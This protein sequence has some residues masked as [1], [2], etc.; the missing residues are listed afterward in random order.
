MRAG[1][2]SFWGGKLGVLPRFCG[3]RDFCRRFHGR[4]QIHPRI[5][6]KSPAE[7]HVPAWV[8]LSR[9]FWSLAPCQRTHAVPDSVEV[10]PTCVGQFRARLTWV[11]A[12][13]CLY[14]DH[15]CWVSPDCTRPSRTAEVASESSASVIWPDDDIGDDDILVLEEPFVPASWR[16]LGSVVSAR[17]SCSA[18]RL[19]CALL[20]LWLVVF[21]CLFGWL[22]HWLAG[23][24]ISWLVGQL[25]GWLAGWSVGRLVGWLKEGMCTHTP[26]SS[27]PMGLAYPS[28][29]YR[30]RWDRHRSSSYPAI[31]SSLCATRRVYARRRCSGTG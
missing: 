22:A 15:R 4:T 25:V 19:P 26:V 3:G 5:A 13:V 7:T 9:H 8:C 24:L 6:G 23:C 12:G 2:T 16:V 10:A 17:C 27:L 1:R 11:S 18:H 31:W 14:S 29:S 28:S 20:E 21:A 30:F